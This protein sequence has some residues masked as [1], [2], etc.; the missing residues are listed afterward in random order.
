LIDG[1][2]ASWAPIMSPSFKAD[3]WARGPALA[4]LDAVSDASSPDLQLGGNIALAEKVINGLRQAALIPSG[5]AG[6]SFESAD[7]P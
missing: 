5:K 1:R 6:Q 2:P 3:A 4:W 7:L